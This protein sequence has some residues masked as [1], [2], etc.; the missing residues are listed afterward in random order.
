MIQNKLPWIVTA[1]LA[2]ILIIVTFLWLDAVKKLDNGNLS[3]ER[4]LIREYCTKDDDASRALCQ[5]ELDDMTNMLET[6]ARELKK[7]PVK[8][9]VQVVSSTTVGQ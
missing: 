2:A 6:F 9:Q 4:D 7:P 1:V 5:Q 3:A 8:T